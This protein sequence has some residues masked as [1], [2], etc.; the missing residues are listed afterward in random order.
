M[1]TLLKAL[2]A[3]AI[4]VAAAG[5]GGGGGSGGSPAAPDVFDDPDPPPVEEP[6]TATPAIDCGMQEPVSQTDIDQPAGGL[7]YGTLFN[8]ALGIGYDALAM[9]TEDGRFRILPGDQ[10][11]NY[12]LAG[13]LQVEGDVFEGSGTEFDGAGHTDFTAITSMISVD[14]Y[15]ASH[16]SLEGRWIGPDFGNYGYFSFH[17]QWAEYYFLYDPPEG[18]PRTEAPALDWLAGNYEDAFN[19]SGATISWTVDDSGGI[20][21][22]DLNGCMYA[23][24]I[25]TSDPDYNLY[26]VQ[27]AVSGCALDGDYA[28]LLYRIYS[29]WGDPV[30]IVSMDDG[31]KT[32]VNLTLWEV[33]GWD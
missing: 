16:A 14:G 17:N 4:V 21:G 30:L 20:E 27:V 3:S 33:S 15:V 9:V 12:L 19:L 23:G 2:C 8:C 25:S 24:E 1:A 29:G 11:I 18:D 28:G 31:E 7:Y 13:S 26:D 32:S 6:P 5:C 22:T 10:A